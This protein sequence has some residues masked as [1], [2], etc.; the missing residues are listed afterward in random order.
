MKIAILLCGHIRTWE[1]CLDNF[2]R[3]FES[4]NYEI[5]IFVHTY[6]NKYGYHP[7]IM[8]TF[9]ISDNINLDTMVDAKIFDHDRYKTVVVEK[10]L[11]ENEVPDLD[12]YPVNLDIYS[13]IRKN[14]LCNEERKKWEIKHDIVYD[15]I[16][17]TRM[18]VL[19]CNN[20]IIPEIIEKN[21]IYIP[22]CLD[23]LFPSDVCY[24][25]DNMSMNKLL[26][27]LSKKYGEKIINPH[28]WLTLNL[29]DMN[30]VQLSSNLRF[31]RLNFKK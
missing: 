20:F 27:N 26:E 3:A 30:V 24:M 21:T 22:Q 8:Q 14:R 5:S 17:K 9:G 12:E 11:I 2:L 16:I 19:Y 4:K 31:N 23:T 28:A 7:H 18:D 1:E 6:S 15:L 25:G 29:K 13:Q 10:E